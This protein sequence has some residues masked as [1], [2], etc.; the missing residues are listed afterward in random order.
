MRP[1]SSGNRIFFQYLLGCWRYASHE[2][3]HSNRKR[4]VF[5]G[6]GTCWSK[7]HVF[8][9][10]TKNHALSSVPAQILSYY[11]KCEASNFSFSRLG[12]YL[13]SALYNREREREK[14]YVQLHRDR[15]TERERQRTHMFLWFCMLR[16]ARRLRL[17]AECT[18]SPPLRHDQ[19]PLALL[20]EEM[21]SKTR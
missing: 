14:D 6:F 2:K 20:C 12:M 5:P 8:T 3:T 11:L 7:H 13:S 16:P 1:E 21:L 19:R 18:V 10:G 17:L 15:E 4:V 9:I